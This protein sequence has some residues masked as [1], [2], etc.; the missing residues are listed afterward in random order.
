[1][2]LTK[3]EET[4]KGRLFHENEKLRIF[5]SSC[6]INYFYQVIFFC[7]YKKIKNKEGF[8]VI[9]HAKPLYLCVKRENQSFNL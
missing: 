4:K 3:H 9:K 7:H 1:M 2:I 8:R 6:S 5:V